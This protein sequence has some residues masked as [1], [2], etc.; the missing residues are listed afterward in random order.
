M[1]KDILTMGYREISENYWSKPVGY[2]M[3]VISFK[4]NQYK[5][6]NYFVGIDGD[7]HVYESKVIE[8]LRELKEAESYTKQI[9][10]GVDS[11]FQFLSDEQIYEMYL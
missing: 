5:F 10:N 8:D 4:D 9:N 2:S 11:Q 1:K 3:Y 7:I 6:I